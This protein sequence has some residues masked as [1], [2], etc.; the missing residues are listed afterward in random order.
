MTT[1][2]ATLLNILDW[3]DTPIDV[4]RLVRVLDRPIARNGNTR[5]RILHV[6]SDPELRRA[7]GQGRW[8]PRPKSCRSI[9]SMRRAERSP[10]TA[11]TS[12]CSMSRWP[13]VPALNLLHELRNSEGD[14]I[15]L[16]VFSPQDAN[17]AFAVQIRAALTRSRTSIDNLIATL[18]KR[19]AAQQLALP[20]IETSH[21]F[22]P[23]ASDR[24][25]ARYP[26]D[27]GG[28]AQPRSRIRG[29]RLRF[30][31][32][33][34]SRCRAMAARPHPA[35]RHDAGHGRAGDAQT[36]AGEPTRPPAFRSFS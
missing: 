18:R 33:R 30:G 5:P 28:F 9:R 29:A 8:A 25:R 6:D 36:F 13:R 35:R 26:R 11:S 12:P 16:V 20:T 24:R 2:P 22:V 7:R 32:G 21:E 34:R 4:A 31:R 14:A 27:R 10:P 23:R 3:L 15:P 17:P 19:L 1:Q